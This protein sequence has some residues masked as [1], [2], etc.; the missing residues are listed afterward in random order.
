MDG[1]V[2]L[3]RHGVLRR[4]WL[5]FQR[6][7]L[8]HDGHRN[9]THR[10]I[11]HADLTRHGRTLGQT[12]MGHLLG[13][14]RA[15]DVNIDP[16]VP[17]YRLHFFT[18]SDRRLATCRSRGRHTRA[19][20]RD[21]CSNHLLLGAVVEHA[22]SGSDHSDFAEADNSGG[23]AYGHADH[24]RRLLA[25]LSGR[26][27][28]SLAMHYSGKRAERFA[29][30]GG[31]GVIMNWPDLSMG[32]YGFFVWGSYLFSLVAIVWELLSLKQ[33]KKALAQQRSSNTVPASVLRESA[34]ETTS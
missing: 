34:N 14:G 19:R 29:T 10:R 24:A 12:H 4:D 15:Y 21:K 3:S 6:A 26:G 31:G 18:G 17:L 16:A 32:G 2:P 20:R 22:S 25:L 28:D 1:N 30:S 9:R 5:G 7:T 23:D 27:A 13:L 33:R 11:V 8:L